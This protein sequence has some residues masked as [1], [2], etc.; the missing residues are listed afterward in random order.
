[1][2]GRLRRGHRLLAEGPGEEG[3][4]DGGVSIFFEDS[5]NVCVRVSG[6]Y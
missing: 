1:M 6:V 4:R 3:D 2:D 5:L